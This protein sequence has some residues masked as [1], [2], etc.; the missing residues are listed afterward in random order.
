MKSGWLR[1]RAN[2]AV[3][4]TC[5]WGA[6]LSALAVI[7]PVAAEPKVPDFNGIWG[8]YT[9]SYPKPY[10]RGRAV[11]DGYN[12]EYLKPWV[13]DLLKQD[14]LVA[15]SGRAL[16]TAHSLCYPEGVP[17]VFGETRV[18]ILQTPS[19]ITMLFG[20]EQEQGR[21]IYLDRPHSEHVVPSWFGESVGHFEGDSLVVDTVGVAAKPQSGSMGLFGTPHT[22]ALHIVERYRFLVEGEKTVG[23][24]PNP[25]ASNPTIL[26][27]EIVKGGKTLRL[28]FTVDDPGAYKKP[29]SVT[30]DFLP[31]KTPIQEYVCT[32]NY[33]E[34][35]LLPLIP[36]ADSPDF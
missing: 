3:L 26:A 29:W 18:Q 35:D 20:G 17:Y 14:D 36:H 5:A 31:L 1:S 9:Y 7:P 6:V 30:L 19:E 15:A 13:V 21:T 24:G 22:N 28:D 2:R 4:V 25:T 23:R 27:D 8:K 16:A 11:A 32:E 33:Q 34:K 12:N 10:M